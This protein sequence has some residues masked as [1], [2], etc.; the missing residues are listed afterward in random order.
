MNNKMKLALIFGGR[1]GEYAVSLMSARSVASVVDPEK[2]DVFQIGITQE[3]VWLTGPEALSAFEAG[4]TESL[5]VAVLLNE[6]GKVCLYSRL[7]DQLTFISEIDVVF[8]VLHG[9]FGEDGTIQGFFEIT[10]VAYAGAGVLASSV[11]MDK[12]LCKHVVQNAG[13]PVLEYTVFNRSEI[14]ADLDEVIRKSEAVAAYPLFVKPANLGSSVG[15]SK[16]HNHE[17][18]RTALLKA[19]NFDRRILVERG[20]EAREIEISVLGNEQPVCSVPGEIIPDDIFYTYKEKYFSGEPELIIPAPF[21]EDQTKLIQE[22]ALRIFKAIDGAG[23]ARVDFLVDKATGDLYFNEI[24][25]IPGFTKISMYPKLWKAS[26][27]GYAALVD[28]LIQ[29]G[30]ERKAE[31]DKTVRKFEE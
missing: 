13:V 29:L 27:L 25:T 5:S 21:S 15:I 19:A 12:A 1:S 2:Y 9:T 8:P 22:Y 10:G 17:E 28:K 6:A 23:M 14:R 16:A 26:G 31:Q 30:L 11:G 18:L 4:Q 7:S 20:I 3:G 24:N